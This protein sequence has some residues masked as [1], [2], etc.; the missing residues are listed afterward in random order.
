MSEV[1]A[2]RRARLRE[3]C[4]AGGSA[5]A[6]ITRPAN[7]RYLAG[8]APLGTVLLLGRQEDVLVCSGPPGERPTP[9]GRPDES[10]RPAHPVRPG[11]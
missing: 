3:R 2:A 11:R 10:L 6:L 4:Q 7:V 5:S 9:A 1:Y 8:P